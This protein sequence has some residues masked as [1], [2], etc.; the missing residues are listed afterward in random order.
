MDQVSTV[1]LTALEFSHVKD[2]DGK[3]HGFIREVPA[4]YFMDGRTRLAMF[5]ERRV[6]IGL[7]RSVETACVSILAYHK[8][9]ADW[10]KV[11]FVKKDD[12]HYATEGIR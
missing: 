11:P 1:D 9:W 3:L 2:G 6:F 12:T 7:A 10:I 8:Q 5:D 4:I